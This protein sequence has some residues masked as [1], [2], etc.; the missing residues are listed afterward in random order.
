MSVKECRI[1]RSGL[2]DSE[3]YGVCPQCRSWLLKETVE[4][5]AF[6]SGIERVQTALATLGYHVDANGISID[7]DHGAAVFRAAWEDASCTSD[8]GAEKAKSYLTLMREH[9]KQLEKANGAASGKRRWMID[10]MRHNF[11]QTGYQLEVRMEQ[12]MTV[13]AF[14]KEPKVVLTVWDVLQLGNELCSSLSQRKNA[15]N[16]IN[17]NHIFINP[18]CRGNWDNSSSDTSVK[19]FFVLEDTEYAASKNTVV[20]TRAPELN[21]DTAPTV[22]SDIYAVGM[23]MYMLLNRNNPGIFAERDRAE[24]DLEENGIFHN[25]DKNVAEIIKK[26]ISLNPEQRYQTFVEMQMAL[27]RLLSNEEY[28]GIPLFGKLLPKKKRAASKK[29][30]AIAA[31]AAALLLAGAIGFFVFGRGLLPMSSDVPSFE[32]T[33]AAVTT[34][35]PEEIVMPE[36]D[37]TE[38]PP[39][40]T[41][42]VTVESVIWNTSELTTTYFLNDT[43][44]VS[45]LSME[46]HY[47]DGT[48][49]TVTEGF[50]CTPEQLTAPGEQTVT[51]SYGEN[52]YEYTVVVERIATETITIRRKPNKTTYNVNESL[53]S[54]G[55]SIEVTRTDGSSET[56]SKGFNWSPKKFT[57]AGNQKVTVTYG[58]K[59]AEFF[60]TVKD[61]SVTSISVKTKPTKTVYYVNDTLNTSGLSI[62]AKLSD[63]TTQTLTQTGDFTCTP[64]KL[65]K[66]GEQ[67]ITVSY[68]GKTTSFVVQVRQSVVLTGIS[69]AQMPNKTKYTVGD[70]FDSTGLVLLA[71]YSDG[72]SARITQ[73]FSCGSPD[74]SKAAKYNVGVSYQGQSTTFQITVVK[75]TSGNKTPTPS[76]PQTNKNS[77]TCGNSLKWEYKNGTLSISGKGAMYDYNQNAPWASYTGSISKVVIGNTVTTIGDMAF[78]GCSSLTSVSIPGSVTSIGESA[79]YGC[80]SLTSIAIPYSV[81]SL[82]GGAFGSC[83]SLRTVTISGSISAI[84][85]STFYDCYSL[86]SITIPGSVT[87]IK[88]YAF[89]SC[90]SLASV[91]MSGSVTTIGEGAFSDCVSLTSLAIPDSVTSIG[92]KAFNR[93]AKL[94][95]VTIPDSVTSIGESAFSEC[96]S[97]ESVTIPG[98]VSSTGKN[99]FYKCISLKEIILKGRNALPSDWNKYWKNECYAQVFLQP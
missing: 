13:A 56:L 80:K 9:R 58:G 7:K 95:S 24:I 2:Q 94:T 67:K 33:E 5:P 85:S 61:I 34:E 39:E 91:T 74:M 40:D 97:L 77:G 79:F 57:K 64:G 25:I 14:I 47:S 50:T 23:T 65:T 49:E 90:D 35:L 96:Q 36:E 12:R 81:T 15:H 19:P 69:V 71:K 30:A 84:E 83:E 41:A 17:L 43:P 42:A 54:A 27:C 4:D 28:R 72:T 53:N 66:A 8:N 18:F 76:T 11:Q 88:S 44:D 1:C 78:A 63:G 51:V 70:R 60:V 16:N 62:T 82:G 20:Y 59:T 45:G 98:S 21:D 52:T 46:L 89:A 86:T 75:K 10:Y 68:G 37:G 73:G 38:M 29:T 32:D 3:H 26:A 93:C 55:L 22:R 92:A 31:S 87:S 99:V 48:T 6:H